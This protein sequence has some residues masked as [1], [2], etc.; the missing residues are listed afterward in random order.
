MT[1]TMT[2]QTPSPRR[3]RGRR[4]GTLERS[5]ALL[6]AGTLGLGALSGC[7][8]GETDVVTLDFFQFKSEAIADFDGIIADF[9]A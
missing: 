1:D 4:L 8:P 6:L 7:A 3:H 2:C 9:E 5:V